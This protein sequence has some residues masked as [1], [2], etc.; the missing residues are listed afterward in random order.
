[1]IGGAGPVYIATTTRDGLLRRL[2]WQR[3]LAE[4]IMVV[5]GVMLGG[6]A[7]LI[8]AALLREPWLSFVG[9]PVLIGMAGARGK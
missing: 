2:R 5:A 8:G 9:V 4:A 1:M 6:G 3:A 7:A